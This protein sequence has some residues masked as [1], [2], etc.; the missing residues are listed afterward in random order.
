MSAFRSTLPATRWLESLGMPPWGDP[1]L[2]EIV[3]L[4]RLA[5]ATYESSARHHEEYAALAHKRAKE[6]RGLLADLG[7]GPKP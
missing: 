5:L 6:A 4:L 1:A 2:S 7:E 3:R